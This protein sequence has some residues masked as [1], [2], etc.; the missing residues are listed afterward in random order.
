MADRRIELT[1]DPFSLPTAQH[2][3]GLAGLL[4]LIESMRRRKMKRLPEI[5]GRSDSKVSVRLTKESLTALFSDFYDATTEEVES[6]VRRKDKKKRDVPPLREETKRDRKTGRLKT[7]YF[8]PQVIPK[9]GFLKAY[10]M[11]DIWL[12]L[13]RE[14]LWQTLRGRPTTRRPFEERARGKAVGEIDAAW[15]DLTR[16]QEA[17]ARNE[18]HTVEIASPVFVG[19]QAKNAERVPF[20]GKA[21]EALLLHFWPIVMGVYVPEAINRDGKTEFVGYTLAVPDVT[22]ADGFVE[23]FPEVVANLRSEA[24]GYRPREAVVSVP[25]EGGLEY[26]RNVTG[27]AKAKAG[28]GTT[29]Y[30]VAGVEVYHLDK[31]DKSVHVLAADRVALSQAVVEKYEAIRGRYRDPLFR[32]QIVLNLLRGELSYRGFDRVFA[33][34]PYERFVGSRAASFSMDAR[35]FFE[36]V[37][38]KGRSA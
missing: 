29:A 17:Q 1:Y 31:R 24:A 5:L 23:D 34:I 27:L 4:V 22:D 7:A 33:R 13:W 2:R 37:P 21:D 38:Q 9:A 30:N 11:P 25:V 3:A 6:S 19:A 10:G 26:L 8:Y 15:R 36:R 28:T 20:R 16:F 32:R 12:K 14:A 18:I 35:R